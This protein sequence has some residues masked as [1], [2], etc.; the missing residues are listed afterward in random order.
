MSYSI[1]TTFHATKHPYGVRAIASLLEGFPEDV[2][3][4]APVEEAQRLVVKDENYLARLDVTEFGESCPD[5]DS[6]EHEFN[7]TLG[8]RKPNPSFRFDAPR[9]A[10]KTFAIE[11]AYSLIDNDDYLIWIDSDVF[12]FK[13]IKHDFIAQLCPEGFNFAYLGRDHLSS[14]PRYKHVLYSECGFM[15]FRKNEATTDF[16]NRV[17]EVYRKQ[18]FDLFP[19]WHDCSVFDG[20][21]YQLTNENPKFRAFDISQLG[22]IPISDQSHV[23]IASVLGEYMDHLKG[24]RKSKKHSPEMEERL[25]M[26]SK[27]Q[28]SMDEEYTKSALERLQ[29]RNEKAASRTLQEGDFQTPEIHKLPAYSGFVECLI[30]GLEEAFLMLTINHDDMVADKFFFNGCYERSTLAL[31]CHFAKTATQIIDVG[32]HTGVYSLAAATSNPNASIISIEPVAVNVIRQRSNLSVNNIQ[33]VRVYE[34]VATDVQGPVVL[35]V[36]DLGNYATQGA[37]LASKPA[38]SKA[39]ELPGVSLD[40]ALSG[41]SS[42][43]L[44]KIDAEGGE[45]KVLQGMVKILSKHQ[46]I[47]FFECNV[48]A[49]CGPVERLLVGQNYCLYAVDDSKFE[50]T[51]VPDLRVEKLP[52]GSLARSRMNRIAV[53]SSQVPLVEAAAQLMRSF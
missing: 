35:N 47:V 22:L 7:S 36:P 46:P 28:V 18:K 39:L 44:V 8:K 37:S 6:F 25:V 10:H 1:V 19:E 24:A 43:D 30:T 50:I 21:R 9:F 15:I 51:R 4:L 42:V 23:F 27:T 40:V 32:S 41:T 20:I 5:F 34:C 33:N 11:Y 53:H 49:I 45:T 31:W 52:D 3:V 12:V 26:A 29:I 17:M 48:E 14:E 2:R 16:L 13:E 38:G